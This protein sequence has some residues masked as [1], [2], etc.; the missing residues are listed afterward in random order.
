MTTKRERIDGFMKRNGL[1]MGKETEHRLSVYTEGLTPQQV[2]IWLLAMEAKIPYF[3]SW[4]GAGSLIN[5]MFGNPAK[6]D[7]LT[8]RILHETVSPDGGILASASK[9]VFGAEPQTPTAPAQRPSPSPSATPSDEQMRQEIWDWYRFK[10]GVLGDDGWVLN[11]LGSE[12]LARVC[13]GSWAERCLDLSE[14]PPWEKPAA[15]KKFRLDLIKSV[16]RASVN[17][18]TLLLAQVYEATVKGKGVDPM[19]MAEWDAKVAATI[20]F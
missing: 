1:K 4:E 11:A 6:T 16:K 15:I 3:K 9:A 8:W 7:N 12:W 17:S 13:E 19:V 5:R 14:T 2:E 18:P 20:D 10:D